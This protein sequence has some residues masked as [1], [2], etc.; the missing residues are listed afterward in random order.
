MDETYLKVAC[1]WQYLY[2][3]IDG[4]LVD[5][6]LSEARSQAAAEAFFRS[7][8][9]VTGITPEKVTTDKHA[10]FPSIL[11]RADRALERAS[12][13]GWVTTA[14]DLFYY[15][16]INPGDRL[17][18]RRCGVDDEANARIRWFDILSE[19][20]GKRIADGFWRKE[21]PVT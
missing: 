5:V 8:I 18:V 15:G 1:Q 20:D 9:A 16:N 10:S 12:G 19:S 3:A 4:H 7:D 13:T 21:K 2:R 11:D 6:Y 17:I 14:P